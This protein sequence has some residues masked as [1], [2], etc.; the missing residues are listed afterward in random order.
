MNLV[1]SMI[2]EKAKQS[3]DLITSMR[4]KGKSPKHLE[5]EADQLIDIGAHRR[6]RTT[7]TIWQRD[8]MEETF[9]KQR[10]PSLDKVEQLSK[11]LGLPQYVIKVCMF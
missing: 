5:S 10:Y 11:Q 8:K 4:C 7:I 6:A 9:S 1:I 3:Q 2:L